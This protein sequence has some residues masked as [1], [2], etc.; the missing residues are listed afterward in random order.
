MAETLFDGNI[1]LELRDN[2]DV[3]IAQLIS[4]NL[5][6]FG[7]AAGTENTDPQKMPKVKKGEGRG[8]IVMAQD[9]KLVVLMR[10]DTAATEA[11]SSNAIVRKYRIPVTQRNVRTN[12]VFENTLGAG[13]FTQK[14][15]TAASKVHA[16]DEW[17]IVDEYTIPAQIELQLGHRLQDVRVDSAMNAYLSY[18]A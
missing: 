9:D 14:I 4:K 7:N 16:K 10:L 15:A 12:V 13:D 17:V 3:P 18:V 8:R 2:S 6:E 1:R 5:K 11:A